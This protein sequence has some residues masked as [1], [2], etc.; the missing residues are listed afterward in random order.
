MKSIRSLLT[1]TLAKWPRR[2]ARRSYAKDGLDLKLEPFLRKRDGFFIEAGANDGLKQ[3]NTLYFERHY[4]WR[5]LLVE[6]VPEFAARCRVNRP[7]CVVEECALVGADGPEFLDLT[8]AGLMS[9]ADGAFASMDGYTR[10]DHLVRA[11]S[12]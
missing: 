8:V 1:R 4:G 7:G 10:E 3:S 9:V 2:G 12:C 11:Q 6:P 5:G